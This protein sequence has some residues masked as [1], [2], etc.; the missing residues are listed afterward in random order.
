MDAH[1]SVYLLGRKDEMIISGGY[2]IAPRE[3]EEVIYLHPAVQECAVI[4]EADPEWGQ[5]VVA[6]VAFRDAT[7]ESDLIEFLKPQL[8]FK[9]P[10]RVYRVRELPKNSNGKIQKTVLKPELALVA[11]GAA[12]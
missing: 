6:Y 11:K 5:A 1:G 7:T 3:I 8:G 12:R 4:G 10:K 9:R 2:N